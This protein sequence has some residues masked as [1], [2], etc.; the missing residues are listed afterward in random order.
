MKRIIAVLLFAAAPALGQQETVL[1]GETGNWQVL[2]DPSQGN[3]CFTYVGYQDGSF[4]RA[5]YDKRDDTAYVFFG[6]PDWA[7]LVPGNSYTLR[8]YFDPIE[9]WWDADALA[10]E[11]DD[12]ALFL[13]IDSSDEN[14]LDDVLKSSGARVEFNGREIANYDLDGSGR[15]VAMVYE[16][17]SEQGSGNE[18]DPFAT[19]DDSSDSGNTSDPFAN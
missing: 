7:S 15:A 18:A 3:G 16:C 11:F 8:L 17:Q 2:V 6:D 13:R 9:S 14:L 10:Q 5:G 1:W 4:F 19:G 12:G